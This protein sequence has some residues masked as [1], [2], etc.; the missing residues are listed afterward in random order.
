M[1]THCWHD[2]PSP[3]HHVVCCFCGYAAPMTKSEWGQPHHGPYAPKLVK[4]KLPEGV[5]RPV[6]PDDQLHGR[7]EP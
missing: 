3:D 1:T 2:L 6:E 5:C 7:I 4:W